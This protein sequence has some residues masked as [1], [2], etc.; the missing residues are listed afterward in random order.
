[1]S[2]VLDYSISLGEQQLST[3][4]LNPGAQ[5]RLARITTF[6]STQ[7]KNHLSFNVRATPRMTSRR[8]EIQYRRLKVRPD[9]VTVAS[10]A[11]DLSARMD[12]CETEMATH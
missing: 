7:S 6:V 5:V 3:F 11:D 12:L 8:V 10:D 2:I 4:I 9:Y 1:M